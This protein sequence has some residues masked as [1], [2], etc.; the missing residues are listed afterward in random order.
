MSCQLPDPAQSFIQCWIGGNIPYPAI[1]YLGDRSMNYL[2]M[3][4]STYVQIVGEYDVYY[5]DI[6]DGLIHI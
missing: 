4:N 1:D 6:M 2:G 5:D 3:Y